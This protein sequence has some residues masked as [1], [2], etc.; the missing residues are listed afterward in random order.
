M[1]RAP[2]IKGKV[3]VAT[4][5]EFLVKLHDWSTKN[6][7]TTFFFEAFDEPWKGGGDNSGASEIE[8]NWGL[9]YEDRSP[10]KSFQKFINNKTKETKEKK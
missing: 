3:G 10:K 7:V 4:Q 9:F 8:K 2:L 5:G 1:N 6:Q